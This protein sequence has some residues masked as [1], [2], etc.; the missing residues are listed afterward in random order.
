M[1]SSRSAT[2]GVKRVRGMDGNASATTYSFI[3]DAASGVYRDTTS[4]DTVVHASKRLQLDSTEQTIVL[5]DDTLTI[6][7]TGNTALVIESANGYVQ[8]E[9]MQVS[10][11]TITSA[12][13]FQENIVVPEPTAA[14]HPATKFYTDAIASGLSL[15]RSCRAATTEAL[16]AYTVSDNT[17]TATA[18]GALPAIDGVTLLAND[19]VLVK[20][21]SA[22]QYNGIYTV[23]SV[24]SVS[25]PWALT[26][27]TDADNSPGQEVSNGMFTFLSEG[28]TQQY[29]GYALMTDSTVVLNTTPLTF[30]PFSNFGLEAVSPIVRSGVQLSLSTVP[31]SV[32][33]TG[34][35][36]A[37]NARVNLGVDIGT[38][39]QAHHVALDSIAGLTTA[40]N[41]MI[42][43]TGA[44]TYATT[45]LTAYARTLLDDA[46]ATVARATLG[47]VPG[48]DVQ[49]Q[50]A[51]LQSIASLTTSANETLYTTGADTYATTAMTAFG[52]SLIDDANAAV[53]QSTLGLV[54]GTDVQAHHA[55]LDSIAALTTA[56]NT[57]I[58]ATA[59][60]TYAT[61]TLTP[62][63][64]TLLDDANATVARATLGLVVGTDVQAYDAALDSIAA[65]ATSADQMLY[66]TGGT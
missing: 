54:P 50:S 46:N 26:R 45:A 63:A 35:T 66:T 11:N 37:A 9:A 52:R 21:E 13:T 19:R 49:T 58:Y 30:E 20:N 38:D 40:A 55:A 59:S 39:V 4:G 31:V 47:V 15:K 64:R 56:A 51:A 34:A 27:A 5:P 3:D 65:L 60:D 10:G 42:Y 2:L 61:A 14:N 53:A 8:I 62:Y 24:G 41:T 48:T 1:S 44:N 23:D 25:T 33:G 28:D 36:T 6:Q 17:L 29:V 7:H 57:M 12:M 43:T 22:S 18:N 16:P 32:G